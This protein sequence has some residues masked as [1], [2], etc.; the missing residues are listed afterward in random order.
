L[1]GNVSDFNYA[2]NRILTINHKTTAHNVHRYYNEL[3]MMLL[4]TVCEIKGSEPLKNMWDP[5]KLEIFSQVT[6]KNKQ[7]TVKITNTF[8]K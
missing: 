8:K 5:R 6:T 1:C 3:S 2:V 7:T 4:Y